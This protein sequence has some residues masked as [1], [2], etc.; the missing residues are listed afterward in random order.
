MGRKRINFMLILMGTVSIVLVLIFKL[1]LEGT[2]LGFITLILCMTKKD[3]CKILMP[4][5]A[6]VFAVAIGIG[7]LTIMVMCLLDGDH[8]DTD[9]WLI[10]LISDDFEVIGIE[11]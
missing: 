7:N 6:S 8:I 10:R 3:E 9:Y 11:P 4:V 2:V 5:I 1:Y